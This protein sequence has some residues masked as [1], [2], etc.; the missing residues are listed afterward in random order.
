MI[1]DVKPKKGY[2]DVNFFVERNNVI[3][4]VVVYVDDYNF[5]LIFINIVLYFHITNPWKKKNML[6]VIFF[7]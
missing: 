3:E 1:R 5:I 6:R 7:G 4:E 2:M